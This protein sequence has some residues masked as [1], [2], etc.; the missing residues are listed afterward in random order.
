MLTVKNILTFFFLTCSL[1]LVF[2]HSILP[3]NHSER[4]YAVCEISDKEE[5]S[6]ADLFTLALSNDL[7]AHH[8]EEYT[9]SDTQKV[10]LSGITSIELLKSSSVLFPQI[11]I[12]TA[13]QVSP[14]IQ[15]QFFAQCSLPGKGLRAPPFS[16]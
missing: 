4:D 8:L 6:F 1:V 9:G 12:L 10:S 16:V 2:G 7:G 13:N 15:F 11:C 5:F 14:L 3:H